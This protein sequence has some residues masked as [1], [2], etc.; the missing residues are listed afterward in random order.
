M[1]GGGFGG[2]AIAITPSDAVEAVGEACLQ[3]AAAADFPTPRLHTVT[4]SPGARRT[5]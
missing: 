2:S 4:V 5:A 1:T 3:A